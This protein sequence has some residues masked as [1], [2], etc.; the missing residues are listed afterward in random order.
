[1]N[2]FRQLIGYNGP[3]QEKSAYEA[4]QL[5]GALM[6]KQRTFKEQIQDQIAYHKSKIADLEAVLDSMSPE[7]ERFVEALQKLN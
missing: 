1:M 5:G 4:G 3:A 2:I 7:V 6:P